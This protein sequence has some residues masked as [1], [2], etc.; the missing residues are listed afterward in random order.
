MWNLDSSPPRVIEA[1]V[2]TR[3]PDSFRRKRRTAWCDANKP[4]HEID[5]FL[6]GPSFDRQGNLWCVDIPYSRIFRI[7]RKGEWELVVQYDGWP[8]GLKFHRDGRALAAGVGVGVGLGVAAGCPITNR[9]DGV[10]RAA[11]SL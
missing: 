1:R 9:G 11:E 6:E 2:L 7:D 10:G 5:S 8:N 4:G 3:L